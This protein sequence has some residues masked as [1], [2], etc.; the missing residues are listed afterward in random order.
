[1]QYIPGGSI[2]NLLARFGALEEEV[3][4]NY[5]KQILEGVV[6][7]HDNNDIHRYGNQSINQS[8]NQSISRT[9][10]QSINQS[11]DQLINQLSNQLINQCV[12]QSFNQSISQ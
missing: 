4:S 1:M 9:V 3:F 11:I 7:L 8:V 2:A 10:S 12:C 5:T 6:Y